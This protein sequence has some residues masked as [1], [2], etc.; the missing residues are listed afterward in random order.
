MPFWWKRR[1]KPWYGR[2]RWRRKTRNKTRRR[3]FP[4]RRG[5]RI[6]RR[7]H[8]RR[9]K[10]RRKLKKIKIQQWQ[11][12]HIVKCKIVGFSTMV[13]GAEGRQFLCWTDEAQEYIQPK[14]PGGGGFGYEVIT[15]EWLY[16]QYKAHN[17]IWTRTNQY[18][19][20]GRYTGCTI[21]FYRHPTTDFIVSYSLQPPFDINK[22]TYPDI[23]PQNMLL[24]PHKKIILSKKSK[25]NGRLTVKLKIKPPKTMTTKWFFQ[26]QLAD[27]P[28]V[29]FRAAAA[30][31]NMPRISPIVQSQMITL[32]YLDTTLWQH[33]NWAQAKNTYWTPIITQTEKESYIFYTKTKT[34]PRT[35]TKLPANDWQS[36]TEGYYKSINKKTGWFQPLVLNAFEMKLRS[37]TQANRPVY[38]ARYN[39]NEDDGSGNEVYVVSLLQNS[40]AAPITQHDMVIRGLPLYMAFYGYYSYLKLTTRDKDFDQYYMFVVKSNAI[41]PISQPTKQEYYPF[42]DKPFIDGTLPYEEYLSE[43]I[44]KFWYPMA[45]YQQQTINAIVESGPFMPKYTNITESTWELAYKY[46]F[47]FKWGGPQ[48]TDPPV[49]DPTGKHIYPNPSDLQERVQITNPKKQTPESLIHEWEYRRGFITQTA[50]K[51]MSENIQTDTDVQSDDSEPKK[52]KRKVTKQVP[53]KQEKEEKLKKC[54]LSLC[55]EPTCQETPENLQQLIL[56]QQQQQQ[57]LKL[58]ILKLLTHLKTQQRYL[59]LQTGHL[60]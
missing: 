39:P 15:L 40:W 21:I 9:R 13:L 42:L 28:L 51:R 56:N 54:L 31:F 41:Q 32:Y 49:D 8:K 34:N 7:R 35:E 55:E 48:V 2:W 12:E 25:P 59:G 30:N 6:T 26:K 29:L 36:T 20:L 57:K 60:E 37:S 43:N 50:L 17:N 3:R 10:V 27:Y 47:Y 46:K 18:T 16:N 1:R 4:R 24:H 58:N 11:P 45:L 33:P 44:E 23:Q 22:L 19:D 14:A 5:R 38:A 52:K 53:L